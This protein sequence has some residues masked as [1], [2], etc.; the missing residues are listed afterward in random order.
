[1]SCRDL[2][3]NWLSNNNIEQSTINSYINAI[4]DL[5]DNNKIEAKVLE[6]TD[7]DFLNNLYNDLLEEQRKP[8]GRYHNPEK[9]SYG[10]KGFYSAAIKKY[11]DFLSGPYLLENAGVSNMSLNSILYG[12]PGT[13][14]TFTSIA[15]AVEIIKGE[16]NNNEKKRTF[17]ELRKGGQIEFVTFHQNYSYED[18][19]VGM[20]P[21]IEEDTKGLIFVPH[22][23][24]FYNIVKRARDN[25]E[26]SLKE[27]HLLIKEKWVNKIFDD[28]VNHVQDILDKKQR[29]DIINNVYICGVGDIWTNRH[30]QLDYEALKRIYI[31]GISNRV[32][33]MGSDYIRSGMKNHATY[34]LAI[35][36]KFKEFVDNNKSTTPE[37]NIEK[38]SLKNYVL[39]I[40]EINRANISKVFGELITLLEEDKRIGSHNELRVSLPNGEKDFGVPPNLYLIGTMNTAD[41]SIALVDI[42]LRRRFE[43]IGYYPDYDKLDDDR[44]KLLKIIN[45]KIYELKKN[46]D[47]LIGHAYFLNN[48][49]IEETLKK[50][51]IPLM[52]EYFSGKTDMV[53]KIFED[54]NWKVEYNPDKYCWNISV[55]VP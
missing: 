17:D 11:I 42:A 50:R 22:Y 9:P 39:I 8:N 49:P 55:K 35:T 27:T 44:S 29:F 19:M 5:Y 37:D 18:F 28:F 53:S 6:I 13:G 14:K 16:V 52:M 7:L 43:F 10:Q 4:D 20:R 45:A 24:I 32:G 23:G 15:K 41:K 26:D 46:S 33:I 21:A 12:P 38:I 34:T 36:E 2:F 31:D 48:S 1:M 51:I 30:L 47:F 3:L 40:D 25:Y 54:T